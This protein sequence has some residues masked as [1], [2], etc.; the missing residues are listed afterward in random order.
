MAV[1]SCGEFYALPED[2]IANALALTSPKDACRLS[3]VASTF[4]SVC[5][6][7][8]VW[9]RFLPSDYRD[10]ISRAVDAPDS[11]LANLH[12]KKDLYLH[13]C[14]NPI[15]IDGGRKVLFTCSLILDLCN[16]SWW[17]WFPSL[18]RRFILP[19]VLLIS[20]NWIGFGFKCNFF[21]RDQIWTPILLTLIQIVT[22]PPLQATFSLT[23]VASVSWLKII[24]FGFMFLKIYVWYLFGENIL[25]FLVQLGPKFFYYEKLV[26]FFWDLIWEETK[27]FLTE[28]REFCL[29]C[30]F[31]GWY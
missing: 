31:L 25:V 11:L 30:T 29:R 6:S 13:L 5:E 24:S 12:S 4:R 3:V 15:L 22:D 14:D 20:C 27:V 16:W 28:E 19:F 26:T 9:D 7:D 2:C 21:L 8:T 18:F 10:I 23:L 1:E 17:R